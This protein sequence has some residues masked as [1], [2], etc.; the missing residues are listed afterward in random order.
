MQSRFASECTSTE[1]VSEK[2]WL[3][4][5]PP[6]QCPYCEVPGSECGLRPHGF[7]DRKTPQGTRVRRFLC[8][9]TG[10]TVSLLPDCLASHCTGDVD[11]IERIAE[12]REE[13]RSL[14]QIAGWARERFYVPEQG[15]E[16][17]LRWVRRRALAVELFLIAIVS[18]YP[19][20][21]AEVEPT[22]T[23]LREHLGTERLLVTLRG[24]AE[25]QLGQLDPPLGL[26]PRPNNAVHPCAQK[27]HNSRGYRGPPP[28][29]HTPK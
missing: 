1:Y 28:K 3:Q 27:K 6:A 4:A 23:A 7:Y 25:S 19:R 5:S 16:G 14:R 20:Q 26:R 17:P 24:L 2:L 29:A 11:T 22:V 8:P 15:L 12:Q 13:K 10:R 18:L 9:C 21:F